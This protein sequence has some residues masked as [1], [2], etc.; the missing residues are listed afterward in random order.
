MWGGSLAPPRYWT[1]L[2]AVVWIATRRLERVGDIEFNLENWRD[3]L[4]LGLLAEEAWLAELNLIVANDC[5]SE[6]SSCSCVDNAIWDLVEALQAG[7]L[8][9]VGFNAKNDEHEILAP[10]AFAFARVSFSSVEGMRLLRTA[11]VIKV[12]KADVLVLW[13]AHKPD[14]NPEALAGK[15]PIMATAAAVKQCEEWLLREFGNPANARV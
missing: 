2:G 1:L 12:G 13:P 9:A 11:P 6:Q 7:T 14:S 5:C 3:W 8:R 15:L 10:E 4:G